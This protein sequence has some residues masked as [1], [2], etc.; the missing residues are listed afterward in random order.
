MGT[1]SPIELATE[2]VAA[3]VSNNSV[4]TSELPAL[5][6][7]VHAAVAR[8]AVGPETAPSQVEAKA[9]AVPI[10]K[11][12]TPDFLICLEDGK[13][14]KTMRRHLAGLG[15]TPEQYRKKWRLP[16]DYP[17]VAPNYAAQRSAMAKKIGLGNIPRKAGVRRS[18]GRSKAAKA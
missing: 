11:S 4:P 7:A 14:F 10:R 1:L 15:L 5:I 2:M 3:F 13:R 18:S 9:P 16:S 6:H 17:M 12:I 8:L